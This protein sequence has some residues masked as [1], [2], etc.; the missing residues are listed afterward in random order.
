L[1]ERAEEDWTR[2][3]FEKAEMLESAGAKTPAETQA[4]KLKLIEGIEFAKQ[5]ETGQEFDLSGAKELLRLGNLSFEDFEAI[6]S[7]QEAQFEAQIDEAASKE[8]EARYT[9]EIKAARTEKGVHFSPT[10]VTEME[11][12]ALVDNMMQRAEEEGW[13]DDINRV[14]AERKKLDAYYETV[15][16]DEIATLITEGR[17]SVERGQEVLAHLE[18]NNI[19]LENA[20][21]SKLESAKLT[22]TDELRSKSYRL[23]DQLSE[24]GRLD[25][26]A[27]DLMGV[28]EG[29]NGAL[30][31]VSDAMQDMR[32][33]DSDNVQEDLAA[34]TG[35]GVVGRIANFIKLRVFGGEKK[36]EAA[37]QEMQARVD[38]AQEDLM[39]LYEQRRQMEVKFLE[40]LP[41]GVLESGDVELMSESGIFDAR[42]SESDRESRGGSV[43]G[44]VQEAMKGY[45]DGRLDYKA[46]LHEIRVVK[47]VMDARSANVIEQES[48]ITEVDSASQVIDNLYNAGH[49]SFNGQDFMQTTALTHSDSPRVATQARKTLLQMEGEMPAALEKSG[50]AELSEQHERLQAVGR[51][52]DLQQVEQMAT[53]LKYTLPLQLVQVGS[54]LFNLL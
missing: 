53:T 1:Y 23:M 4:D 9:R 51:N 35:H 3:L 28:R 50:G 15:D 42:T 48:E 34:M 41:D 27:T 46:A 37:Q 47:E 6:L 31:E 18:E 38:K 44:A 25:F 17:M 26:D 7:Q 43:P 14:V 39:S 29:I 12:G 45:M 19:Q 16:E 5:A 22:R 54:H 49:L 13:A 20:I 32:R 33:A 52:E 2:G 40:V 21:A 30:K 24:A 36:R 8:E 11:K 10:Q